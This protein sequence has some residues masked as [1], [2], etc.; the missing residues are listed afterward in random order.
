MTTK[1]IQGDFKTTFKATMSVLQ[2]QDYIIENTDFN[3]GLIVAEKEL[4]KET[5]A[6]DVLMVIFVDSKHKRSGKVK[7]S[8]TLSSISKKKI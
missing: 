8:A 3:A 2:D 1:E 6:G 4:N 5:T 7:V